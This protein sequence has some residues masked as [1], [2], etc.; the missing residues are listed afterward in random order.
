[1]S[2]DDVGGGTLRLGD[3]PSPADD[4]TP[5][6]L[7]RQSDTKPSA[8][9]NADVVH[10]ASTPPPARYVIDYVRGKMMDDW[11]QQLVDLSTMLSRFITLE[12]FSD[13]AAL[14]KALWFGCV[15]TTVIITVYTKMEAVYLFRGVSHIGPYIKHKRR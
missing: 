8:D 5:R 4:A 6:Q 10:A 7:H 15:L 3:P 12:Y 11:V 9:N 13:G 14:T 1:M 2:A